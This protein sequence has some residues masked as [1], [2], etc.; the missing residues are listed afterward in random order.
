MKALLVNIWGRISL[1][2]TLLACGLLAL[3]IPGIVT[4]TLMESSL[5]TQLYLRRRGG[6][7]PNV[8]G[9]K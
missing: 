1:S 3:I 9:K 2:L 6:Q 4:K 8:G 5:D 7:F